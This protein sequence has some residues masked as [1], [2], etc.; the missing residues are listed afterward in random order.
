MSADLPTPSSPSFASSGLV[1]MLHRSRHNDAVRVIHR[2]R[3]LLTGR[4]EGQ[5]SG[6]VFEIETGSYAGPVTREQAV[7]V[8]RKLSG[9]W[10]I[11]VLVLAIGVAHVVGA[12]VLMRAA[13]SHESQAAVAAAQGD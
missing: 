6:P 3:H 9:K 5:L 10:L 2:H 8:L 13:A 12:S 4:A 1:A 7:R 11:V